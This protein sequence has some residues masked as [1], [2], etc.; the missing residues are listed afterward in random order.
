MKKNFERQGEDVVYQKE[1]HQ[2]E[3]LLEN[4]VKL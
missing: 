3:I 4:I 2:L 1:Q